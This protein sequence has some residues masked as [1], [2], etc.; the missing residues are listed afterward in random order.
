[1]VLLLLLNVSLTT[2]AGGSFSRTLIYSAIHT[3]I[4]IQLVH[5][6]E[7]FLV[8]FS[9]VVK[10]YTCISNITQ[11][12]F[13]TFKPMLRYLQ[14]KCFYIDPYE[15]AKYVLCMLQN[16]FIKCNSLKQILKLCK[17]NS[18]CLETSMLHE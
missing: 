13:V 9:I 5:S 6:A 7:A 1:M 10:C 17:N 12:C 2:A 3:R 15:V 18:K 11:V 14:S 8:L 16:Y 4:S